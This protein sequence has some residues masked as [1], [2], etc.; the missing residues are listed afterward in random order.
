MTPEALE[1]RAFVLASLRQQ[2]A[3]V[4][5]DTQP[6]PDD[7]DLRVHGVIDSLGFVQLL[8]ALEARFGCAIDLSDVPAEQLTNLAVLSRHIAAQIA[9]HAGAAP[10]VRNVNPRRWTT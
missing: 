9:S 5:K 4:G 7:F 1:V 8:G 10:S 2:L 3:A 6:I